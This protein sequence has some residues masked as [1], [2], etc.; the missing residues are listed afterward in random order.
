MTVSNAARAAWGRLKG[1]ARRRTPLRPQFQTTECGVAV[2]RIM[3]AHFGFE[4]P[5]HEIRRVSGVS[6]DCVNAG[7]LRRTAKAFGFDCRV[8]AMETAG[9]RNLALPAIVH[10][11]F[12][13]F[14]VLEAIDGERVRVMCPAGGALDYAYARFDEVFTGVALTLAPTPATPR[15]R[16]E[17]AAERAWWGWLGA[18]LGW[19]LALATAL[20]IA[21]AMGAALVALGLASRGAGLPLLPGGVAAMLLAAPMGALVLGAGRRALY[22][23]LRARLSNQLRRLPFAFHVY[24]LP[25][26]LFGVAASAERVSATLAGS[27]APLVGALAAAALLLATGARLDLLSGVAFTAVAAAWIAGVAALTG[28]AAGRERAAGGGTSS[29]ADIMFTAL[30]RPP[31]IKLANGPDRLWRGLAAHRAQGQA[32]A[33]AQALPSALLQLCPSILTG[34]LLIVVLRRAAGLDGGHGLGLSVVAVALGVVLTPFTRLRGVLPAL[35]KDGFLWRD[36]LEEPLGTANA[37]SVA[38]AAS[39]LLQVDD[40][41]F[42][43]NAGKPVIKNVSLGLEPGEQVGLTGPSGGGKST[44][45]ELITGLYIPSAGQVRI[46]GKPLESIDPATRSRLIARVDRRSVF[47]EGSIR[48]NIALW[49]ETISREDLDAAVADAAL[50]EVIADRAGGLEAPIEAF[51]RNFSGGQLQRLEIARA[52]ARNP[53]IL[54]LDDAVDALDLKTEQHIRAALRRRGCALILI[55][56]RAGSIV[57]CDRV[58]HFSNGSLGR[59]PPAAAPA[60]QDHLPILFTAPTLPSPADLVGDRA[61]A[62]HAALDALM[63]PSGDARQDI[64]AMPLGRAIAKVAQA[65]GFHVRRVRIIDANGWGQDLGDVLA[66]RRDGAPIALMGGRTRRLRPTHPE[67]AL[68]VEAYSIAPIRVF[69]VSRTSAWLEAARHALSGEAARAILCAAVLT[70]ALMAL[71]IAATIDPTPRRGLAILALL[72]AAGAAWQAQFLATQRLDGALRRWASDAFCALAVRLDGDVLRRLSSWS[73]QLGLDGMDGLITRQAQALARAAPSAILLA[74]SV[75]ACGVLAGAPAVAAAALGVLACAAPILVGAPAQL[76]WGDAAKAARLSGRRRLAALLWGV[77]R[78]R[79]LDAEAAAQASWTRLDDAGRRLDERIRSIGEAAVALQGPIAVLLVLVLAGHANSVRQMVVL[80]SL[81]WCIAVSAQRLGGI[82]LELVGDRGRRRAADVLLSHVAPAGGAIVDAATACI[83]ADGISVRYQA[84]GRPVFDALSVTI[85]PSQ[86]TVFA[87]PSGGG[88]STLL[89]VVLGLQQ[90]ETGAVSIGG[91][92]MREIDLAAWRQRIAG[93]FQGDVLTDTITIRGQLSTGA[94]YSLSEIWSALADVELVD[95]IQR[96]PM[97]LQTIVEPGSLST[98]QQQRLLIARALLHRPTLLV[99][100][101]ATNAIPDA[102]QARIV[103]RLRDRGMGCLLITH[104]ASLIALADT[105]HVIEDG[106]LAYSGSP[107]ALA[108]T[109]PAFFVDLEAELA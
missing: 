71:L 58:L 93:V 80:A 38:A 45:A 47:F 30:Q 68:Q 41:S 9:L 83:R 92:P 42:A 102:I 107:Q 21:A 36:V 57:A 4:P 63:P 79:L 50:A 6:R 103:S 20:S 67:E 44:L 28:L 62:L 12:I 3:F 91:H 26:V 40:V 99:M 78:L 1:L 53:K 75:A 35:R 19:R 106:R 100:D 2:L 48:E 108:A 61:E 73:V 94:D 17:A 49:D 54:I 15:L 74:G 64:A 109:D 85:D 11:S 90:P 95:E 5:T 37:A 97:G 33:N 22:D 39:G 82:G 84:G 46:G 29:H 16:R 43:F 66:F 60:R 88:K 27:V 69:D 13:H 104:R 96:M 55:G 32:A 31:S 89:R 7:D 76:R 105:A 23:R 34:G 81:G 59:E 72:L 8:L 65:R 77:G 98:G 25:E 51:G 70:L 86:I 87:G 101:E 24:R 52:L 56:H 10:L 14:V 18:T